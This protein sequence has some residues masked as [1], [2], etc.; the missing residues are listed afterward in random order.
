MSTKNMTYKEIITEAK[1]RSGI[2]DWCWDKTSQHVTV[3]QFNGGVEVR[4][5]EYSTGKFRKTY[6][7]NAILKP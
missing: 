6:I 2:D 4:F 7:K 3:Q 5:Q 1:K